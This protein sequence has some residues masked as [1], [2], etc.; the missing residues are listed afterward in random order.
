[1]IF[2]YLRKQLTKILVSLFTVDTF[3]I[4][5]LLY[6]QLRPAVMYASLI[7]LTV[8]TA[9]LCFGYPRYRTRIQYLKELNA[10]MDI[11]GCSEH[12]RESNDMEIS[13]YQ[14]L[15]HSLAVSHRQYVTKE[16]EKYRDR[17][18]YFAMWAHQIKTPIA[19]MH[20]LIDDHGDP[21]IKDQLFRIEEYVSIVMHYLKTDDITKDFVLNDYALD[22]IIQEAM[23]HY[24]S[25]FIHKKL[26]LD[27]VLTNMHAVTDKKW[28][29]FVI[30][31]IISNSLKY[32]EHGSIRIYAE[33]GNLIIADTG[34]GICAEDL[35]RVGEKGYTGYNGR[36][37]DHAS[38]IGLYLC[39]RILKQLGHTI[40]LKSE[41]GKGTEVILGLNLTKL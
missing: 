16:E 11:E 12:L 19:A 23:R 24:S 10:S 15:L 40:L 1:M 27:Y 38:G 20:L 21:E 18:D 25:Q 41:V 29:L 35:A 6:A 31:Q 22:P 3:L 9:L 5:A 8:G 34:C 7:V 37:D 39:R 32:T 14:D 33:D 13:M 17:S 2:G 30:E 36:I 28:L 4:V 26:K